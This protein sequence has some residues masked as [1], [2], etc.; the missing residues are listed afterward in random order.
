[1]SSQ[2]I[3]HLFHRRHQCKRRA[4]G[5][6]REGRRDGQLPSEHDVRAGHPV[7]SIYRWLGKCSIM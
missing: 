5:H 7:G 2:S 1:M 4:S 6:A 3:W